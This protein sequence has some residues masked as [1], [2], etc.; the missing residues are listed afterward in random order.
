MARKPLDEKTVAEN[1][2]KW[3]V[4]GINIDGCR[5]SGEYKWRASDSKKKGDIFKEGSFGE[6]SSLGR[7]PANLIHD[8]SEEVV[9][10][11][12]NSKGGAFPKTHGSSGFVSPEEKEKRIEMNDSG[13]AARFFY[14]SKASKRERNMGCEGLEEKEGIRTNAPRENEDVKTPT[15][16]NNHPTVKPLAL[17]E[18]LVKLVSRE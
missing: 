3:G 17:M 14:C 12:P 9:G 11:F 8:G 4:G 6:Q 13:S 15:R 2:L 18:Y 10:L 5:V 16:T 1:C 7:F